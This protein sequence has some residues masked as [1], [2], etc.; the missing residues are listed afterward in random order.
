MRAELKKLPYPVRRTYVKLFDL[1]QR[2]EL[3]RN[4]ANKFEQ[5]TLK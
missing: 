2:T 5:S 3:Y 1:K 4:Q